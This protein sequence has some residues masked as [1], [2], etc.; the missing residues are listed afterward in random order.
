[1]AGL[2]AG[3]REEAGLLDTPQIIL[4]LAENENGSMQPNPPF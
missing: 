1:M 3:S 4:G 2:L